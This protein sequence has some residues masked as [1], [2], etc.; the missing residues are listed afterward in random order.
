MKHTHEEI[1]N[2]LHIIKDTCKEVMDDSERCLECPLSN[3]NGFC[4]VMSETPHFWNI[5][6]TD[7]WK[8]FK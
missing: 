7:K 3:K 6:K 4:N 8:A 2:A 1:L 5:K